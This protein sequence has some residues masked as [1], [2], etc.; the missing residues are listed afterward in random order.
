MALVFD[1]QSNINAGSLSLISILLIAS[2]RICI[3]F[4]Q[5]LDICQ[6]PQ[7]HI[8]LKSR[9]RLLSQRVE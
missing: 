4:I 6:L 8:G 7:T 1:D 5:S 9:L 3:R 2:I